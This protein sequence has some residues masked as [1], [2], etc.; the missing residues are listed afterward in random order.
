MRGL[1]QCLPVARSRRALLRAGRLA[2]KIAKQSRRNVAP[3]SNVISQ[4]IVAF[5]SIHQPGKPIIG[6]PGGGVLGQLACDRLIAAL[7][8]NVGYRLVD[9]V[10]AGD[11][12]QMCLTLGSGNFDQIRS[13]QAGR[14]F[15]HGS[16]NLDLVIERKAPYYLGWRVADGR[17]GARKLTTRFSID[18][19]DQDPQH[20]IEQLYMVL[21]E[22]AR[23]VEKQRGDAL[24]CPGAALGRAASN[25]LGQLRSE[26]GGSGH[27]D[28]A[29]DLLRALEKIA[30]S[31]LSS[32][33]RSAK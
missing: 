17:E 18:L 12:E 27:S 29:N 5:G 13:R 26:Q 10:P 25:H 22:A 23:A 1:G 30:M 21:I 19:V 33:R 7:S 16:R 14:A 32:D 20:A 24:K 3:N 6:E 2:Q 9:P 4:H 28:P 8:Q 11:R 31:P 15:E